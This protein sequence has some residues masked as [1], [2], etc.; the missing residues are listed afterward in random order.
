MSLAPQPW[1]RG[2]GCVIVRVRLTPKSS[3]DAVEA[4][5]T[6]TGEPAIAM[7]VRAVPD[8]GAANAALVRLVADWLEVP[9]QA[10]GLA[11]GGKSRVKSLAIK[12]DPDLLVQRLA[13]KVEALNK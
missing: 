9:R 10:V 8:K 4:I 12:G 11:S 3:L 1:R 2:E 7:R 13:T 6:T 5:T